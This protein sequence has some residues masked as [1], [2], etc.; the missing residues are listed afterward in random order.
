MAL[1]TGSPDGYGGYG[2]NNDVFSQNGDDTSVGGNGNN[3]F[4]LR[5]KSGSTATTGAVSISGW[6][7][8]SIYANYSG[9]P[10]IFNLVR[11]IPA[12]QTK[13]LNIHFF[14]I[15]DAT[16]PTSVTVLPPLDAKVNGTPLTAFSGCTGSGVVSGSLGTNCGVTGATSTNY[17]GKVQTVSVPIPDTYT[18]NS[19]QSGGCWVRV[20]LKLDQAGNTNDTTTW[21]ASVDGDPVRMIK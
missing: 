16:A 6:Q 19:T 3:R 10:Q 5:V 12:A 15:G 4:A 8:M 13:T 14:D 17:N 20:Q 21:S 2:G 9:A 1:D 7:N 11:T 18:C